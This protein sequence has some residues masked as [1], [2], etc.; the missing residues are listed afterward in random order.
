[1]PQK[2]FRLRADQIRPL[3]EGHGACFATDMITV[4]G[5]RVGFMY[6]ERP[7]KPPDSG[8]RFF[9]G[10]ETQEY[11]DDPQNTMLYD[12][13]TIANYDPDIVPL[14]HTPF[15]VAFARNDEGL[16]VEVD[17]PEDTG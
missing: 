5:Q 17:S 11:V 16:F 6:R 4:S 7:D 10:T 14:L 8:W 13:N 1:M 15:P 2:H 9:S 12:V 3:A